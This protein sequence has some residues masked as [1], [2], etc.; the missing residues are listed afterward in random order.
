MSFSSV[1]GQTRAI[2]LLRADLAGGTLPPAYL[3]TG[4]DGVGKRL[5]ALQLAK[6]L[7][8]ET[9]GDD[10]CDQCSSCRRIEQ[11]HHPGVWWIEP[12]GAHESLKIEQIRELLP[13][14]SLRPFEGRH[15]VVIIA[16]AEQLTE[17]A[18][19]AL[20][21]KLEEPTGS[22]RFILTTAN[23]AACLPT[24]ISRCRLVPCVRLPESLIVE[25]LVGDHGVTR[26]E[27]LALAH[28]ADGSLGRALER[29]HAGAWERQQ[30]LLRS[31]QRGE[32]Q[33][34][35][36]MIPSGDDARPW[37]QETL[38]LLIWA[39]RQ[40]VLEAA[41]AGET[42]SAAS[43]VSIIA[44]LLQRLDDAN[45]YANAKLVWSVVLDHLQDAVT[46]AAPTASP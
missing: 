19:N 13:R 40:H 42:D 26:D 18:A 43:L 5:L 4:P 2:E 37:L 45:H 36:K 23:R 16:A 33:A 22:T 30:E 28:W 6:A 25:R 29:H 31:M 35:A 10:A 24:V 34:L 7:N 9:G 27:A 12:A 17:E 11:R 39:Y 1:A 21:K 41:S 3:L 32:W 8:C 38:E 44:W 46:P 20:L 15:Q 14:I